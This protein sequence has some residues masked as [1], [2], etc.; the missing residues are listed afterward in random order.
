V[1]KSATGDT[2]VL[3]FS[4]AALSN[5]TSWEANL[6]LLMELLNR[7]TAGT[8]VAV[9]NSDATGV[10][11]DRSQ[12]FHYQNGREVSDD[13]YEQRQF[14]AGQCFA[15]F[16]TDDLETGQ[17][18]QKPILRR[19]VKIPC[20][21]PNCNRLQVCEWI[22]TLCHSHLEFGYTD[23]FLYCE[24][25]RTTY[26]KW[27]FK[28]NDSGHGRGYDQYSNEAQ[29]L[30]TLKSLDQKDYV[31]ILILGETGVGK[32][33]F[34]N[35]FV[36]YL[37]FETLDDAKEQ[38][39]N[40]VIPCSFSIQTMDRSRP[41]GAIEERRIEVGTRDDERDGSKGES[42]TQK[43]AVYPVNIGS[44]TIR[45]IDT[46]GIGDTRGLAY[47]KKN[48]ADILRTLSSYEH[49]HGILILLKSNNSRPTVTFNFCLKELLTHLH[50]SAAQNMAFGFTN[51]RISNYSPGD[52][53]G[54]LTTL[55]AEHKDVGLALANQNTY[56][57]DSESFRF[58]AAYRNGVVME[59][60]LDFRRSWEHSRAE[61]TRLVEYFETRK[62]HFV[63][64]TMSLNGTRQLIAD[65]TKPMLDITQLINTNINLCRE[66]A[67][68][69][70][71][72]RL[73][74]DK[75]RQRLKVEKRHYRVIK[76]PKPRTV[77]RNP[78]C[79]EWQ[80]DGSGKVV[81][82]FTSHCHS[83]CYLD[84]VQIDKVADPGLMKCAAFSGSMLCRRKNC[85]H[86][87]QEHL[88]VLS[89]LEE[90]KAMV[91]DTEAERLFKQNASDVTVRQTAIRDLENL[92]AEYR[93]E[94]KQIQEAAARF[95]IFLKEHSITPYNDATLDYLDMLIQD[96]KQKAAVSRDMSK[97]KDLQRDR[98]AHIE[99]V[100]SLT[101]SMRDGGVARLGE[102]GVEG[103][104]ERLYGLK[105]FGQILRDVKNGIVEA[106]QATYRERPYQVHNKQRGGRPAR[107]S[108]HSGN[109]GYHSGGH[110]KGSGSHGRNSAGWVDRNRGSS[111][112]GSSNTWSSS[113][114]SAIGG[115][116]LKYSN[117][118]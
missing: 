18:I 79:C 52:T 48:M 84:D 102:G 63:K 118:R 74:G 27:K 25:G 14:E 78:D 109:G 68:D 40:W 82:V 69:L 70:L 39:L 22:C 11:Q 31:N 92:V 114:S 100:K 41:E 93:D 57:F 105:H 106:H 35:S 8:L 44:K 76:L 50:R 90:Y 65:L 45:L 61:A 38:N 99:L 6:T 43:T 72:K 71:N 108:H 62:P 58:L 107:S 9:V 26:N 111:S 32:S 53:F 117:P 1:K 33:T 77:C 49:L 104:V 37:T 56:C 60:E 42:A 29:L 64:S 110:G 85:G 2:Y 17:N 98:G 66:Q 7:K 83:V 89:E 80:D 12:V 94:H 28:C 54:P 75:L 95:G 16:E 4:E 23:D 10:R 88:H 51:T 97:L 19:M 15:R 5:D 20:P 86:H 46:P 30:S 34:I 36:N 55:L 24:C 47:D 113:I 81:T 13:L 115:L 96:E 101:L 67:G 59:N 91:T 112:S 3:K 103:L 21:G 116:V 73:S 87:W